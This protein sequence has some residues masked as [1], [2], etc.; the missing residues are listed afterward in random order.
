MSESEKPA[1]RFDVIVIGSASVDVFVKTTT[2]IVHIQGVSHGQAVDEQ[3][4]AYPLGSKLL[5]EKL[6][7]YPGG[8]GTNVCATF[9]RLGFHTAFIGKI[10]TDVQG[11]TLVDWLHD[12]GITFLGERGGQTGYSLILASQANDRTILSFKGCNNELE[13]ANPLAGGLQARWLYGTSMLDQSFAT[14]QRLFLLAGQHGIRTAYNPNPYIC[15][16]GLGYLQKMLQHTDVLML[17][18]EEAGL[19][20]GQGEPAELAVRLATQG[21][22]IVAVTDGAG[23]VTVYAGKAWGGDRWHIRPAEDLK[24]VDTTGAGDAFGSG[25]VAGLNLGKSIREAALLGVLNAEDIIQSCGA[26]GHLA[27]RAGMEE[28]L[29]AEAYNPRHEMVRL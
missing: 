6:A 28:R 18:R 10:G 21:P 19:L 20:A 11:Q 14:Q 26:K 8:A 24:V 15:C 9:A 4:L 5:I 13:L 23:G 27:D 3:W 29:R 2:R 25:L 12:H 1:M 22:G 17:N 16:K 7:F